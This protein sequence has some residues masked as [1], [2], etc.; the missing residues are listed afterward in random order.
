MMKIGPRTAAAFVVCSII[1]VGAMSAAH[2]ALITYSTP[3]GPEAVGATGSGVVEIVYDTLAHTLL[4]DADWSGLSGTTTVAHIHCCTAAPGAGTIGVAVTPVTLP[5]FPVGVQAGSYLSPP[6][7]LTISSTFTAGFITNFAAGVPDDAEEALIAGFDN[8]TAYFN[9]HTT[10]F[11]G[12]EIR[13]FLQRVPEP[14][15]LALLGIG[16]AGLA[17]MRRRKQ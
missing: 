13:G 1:S 9:I 3:L 11:P 7:D 4:I 17:A 5:G 16:L 10:T 6:L 15:S 8:G 2:A 12:G 14:G